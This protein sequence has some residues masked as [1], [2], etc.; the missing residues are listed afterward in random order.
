LRCGE[1]PGVNWLAPFTTAPALRPQTHSR[2]ARRA[3]IELGTKIVGRIAKKEARTWDWLRLFV[4]EAILLTTENWDANNRPAPAQ[5]GSIAGLNRVLGQLFGSHG[6]MTTAVAAGL[7][8]LNRNAFSRMFSDLMGLPFADFV[9]R[10][11]L[12][13]AAAALRQT[14]DPVKSIALSWGF[15]DTS[16][17]DRLFAR[18]YKCVPLEYRQQSVNERRLHTES[19]SCNPTRGSPQ[20]HR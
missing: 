19:G 4:M 6:R 17:L 1:H 16:H 2:S 8:G 9:L 14:Q 10:Y 13:G 3:I 7:C 11:R 20:S 12:G 18:Y 15:V 5:T